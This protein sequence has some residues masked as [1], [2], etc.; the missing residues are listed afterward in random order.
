MSA[1]VDFIDKAKRILW[2][3]YDGQGDQLEANLRAYGVEYVPDFRH[4]RVG[5]SF[6]RPCSSDGLMKS[7]TLEYAACEIIDILTMRSGVTKSHESRFM[8]AL[9]TV[10]EHQRES[11]EAAS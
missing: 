4:G 11:A 7:N 10:Q 2:M 5:I 1:H 6:V 8:N 3:S 9:A